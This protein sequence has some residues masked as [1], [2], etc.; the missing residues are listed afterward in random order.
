MIRRDAVDHSNEPSK[1]SVAVD[2]LLSMRA[3]NEVLLPLQLQPRENIRGFDLWAI[4][5]ENFEH[6]T[7]G[8]DHEIRRESLPQQVF[9]RN[10]AVREIHIGSM[11]DDPTIGLFRHSLIETTIAGLHVKNGALAPLRR[12]DRKAA[13]DIPQD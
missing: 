4:V 11:I 5:A 8:L 13:V 9:S 3:D 1:R 6:R 12:N 2:V 10:R 7:T